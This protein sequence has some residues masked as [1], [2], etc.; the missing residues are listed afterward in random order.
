M[1]LR[2]VLK[3]SLARESTFNL[4]IRDIAFLREAVGKDGR[5]PPVEEVEEPVLDPSRARPKFMDTVAQ[6]VGRRNS[7]PNWA[8]SRM[9]TTHF[10]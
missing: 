9:R 7:C 3:A 8:S 6:H 1:A 4:G 10:A 5:S 2:D